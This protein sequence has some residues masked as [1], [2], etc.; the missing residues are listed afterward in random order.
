MAGTIPASLSG[1]ADYAYLFPMSHTYN[2]NF[3]GVIHVT[4]DVAVSGTVRGRVTIAATGNLFIA[5]DLKYAIAAAKGDCSD[6]DMVGLFTGGDVIVADN[7]LNTPQQLVTSGPY[8]P[9]DDS[10]TGLELQGVILAL[11]VFTVQNYDSGPTNAN[12]CG[13]VAWG[14]GC[15]FL[16]GGVIQQTRG[17]VGQSDGSGF[18]KRYSY[19]VCAAKRPP[20]YFPTTGR[21]SRSQY[22]QID[23]VGFSV[24]GFFA[25][26][27]AG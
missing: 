18:L 14:R 15:L 23:P 16:T 24:G 21:F 19:D 26:W 7:A 25:K 22:F 6:S 3:K 9:L 27:S 20:P 11:D 13:T 5:D 1:R 17:P 8:V 2:P 10:N 12:A 4:G